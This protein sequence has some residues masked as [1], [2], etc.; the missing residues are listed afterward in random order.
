MAYTFTNNSCNPWL[1]RTAPCTIGSHVVYAINATDP[2]HLQRGISFAK[3][4][5]IR[6][7][8]RNTGHDYLGR[9][10]GAHSLALWTR[11]LRSMELLDYRSSVYTGPAIMMGAGVL[12]IEAYR[13]ADSHNVV[14]VGGNCPS[15]G[16]TGGYAQG[17]GISL[18]SSVYGL[19]ADQVLEWTVIT[20]DGELVTANSTHHPDLYWALRGGGGG[21]FGVVVSMTVKVFPDTYTSS[22]AIT[23]PDNGANIDAIYAAF[24]AF[25][26][27]QL[28]T[29]V[30]RGI[31]IPWVL[32]PAGFH[33]E[34]RIAAGLHK[35]ELDGLLQ[36][37][38]S[39]LEDAQLEYNYSSFETPTF[40]GTYEGAPGASN[41]SDY[42]TGGRLISRSALQSDPDGLVAALRHIG[43]QA[44]LTGV[45]FNVNTTRSGMSPDEVAANPYFRES[46]FNLFFGL[47][48]DYQDWD[49]NLARMDKI[50][51]DDLNQ[52]EKVAPNGGA[53]LNEADIAQPDF[54]SV[55]YG[56]HYPRLERIKQRYDPDGVFYAKTAVGSERWEERENGRLCKVKAP[57]RNVGDKV[58][59][60]S[61][62]CDLLWDYR[63]RRG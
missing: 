25:I 4:H 48:I 6:L 60:Y 37:T 41:V 34:A 44:F 20:A 40:L 9:S 43:S 36:P 26:T 49:I 16:M 46:I 52:L 11:N 54:Q 7:V 62:R 53:Y 32:T 50:T 14:V 55:F 23:V 45:S 10:T 31:Y 56:N 8:I 2:T 63:T 19:G 27:T 28:P 30:D 38:L 58:V 21:T 42:V 12:A 17:G 33:L 24:K 61:E 13:F 47:P 18:L 22:A 15:V 35:D 3:R 39:I 57:E 51:N 59:K 1:D 5:N 29:L